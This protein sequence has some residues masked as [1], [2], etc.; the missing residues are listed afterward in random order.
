MLKVQCNNIQ[1]WSIPGGV[2]IIVVHPPDGIAGRVSDGVSESAAL[3]LR[4]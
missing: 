3:V 2:S 4:P 1:T